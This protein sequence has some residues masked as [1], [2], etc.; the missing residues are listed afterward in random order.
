M[1]RA[2]SPEYRPDIGEQASLVNTMSTPG[3]AVV[4]K[5]IASEVDKY[6]LPFINKEPE[7][8]AGVLAAHKMIKAAAQIYD[9][10]LQRFATE[11]AYYLS[12]REDTEVAPDVT[13]NLDIGEYTDY[14]NISEILEEMQ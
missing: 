11:R 14:K 10:L 5:L 13:E 3:W 4:N 12:A 8:E 2:I 6:F 9:A 1:I 7:D